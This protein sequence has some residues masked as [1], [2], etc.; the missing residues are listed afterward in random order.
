MLVL[1]RFAE[2]LAECTFDFVKSSYECA[3]A[4]IN[5]PYLRS[6]VKTTEAEFIR[7]VWVRSHA[8][9]T[10]GAELA[11]LIDIAFSYRIEKCFSEFS[12]FLFFGRI[13]ATYSWS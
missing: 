8:I 2:Y 3:R 11:D 7:I 4:L 1:R 10:N 5:D 6:Q 12:V 9:D 13:L